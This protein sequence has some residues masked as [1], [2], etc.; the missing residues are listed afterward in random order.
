MINPNVF[1][2]AAGQQL[3]FVPV[4]QLAHNFVQ[5]LP[6]LIGLQMS[7]NMAPY[8]QQLVSAAIQN[9]QDKA[10]SNP[11]R[12]FFFNVMAA[13]GFD[14]QMFRAFVQELS[15][16]TELMCIASNRQPQQSIPECVDAFVTF[17]VGFMSLQNPNV[18]QRMPQQSLMAMQQAVQEFQASLQNVQQRMRQAQSQPM[19][20]GMQGGGMGMGGSM[21]AQSAGFSPTGGSIFST[22]A[23]PMSVAGVGGMNIA[24]ATAGSNINTNTPAAT[25]A[26]VVTPFETSGSSNVNLQPMVAGTDGAVFLSSQF[27]GAAAPAPAAKAEV[28]GPATVTAVGD[29]ES[30]KWKP[31]SKFLVMPTFDPNKEELKFHV[32]SDGSIQ[33]LIAAKTMDMNKHLE[34]IKIT[35]G[36][37]VITQQQALARGEESVQKAVGPE[38]LRVEL[39]PE[40]ASFDFSHKE[41]WT[42]NEAY[43]LSIRDKWP[44]KTTMTLKYSM[45]GDTLIASPAIIALIHQLQ[46]TPT[47]T[48]AVNLLKKTFKEAVEA[49]LNLDIRA[50]NRIVRRLWLRTNRFIAV[51]MSLNFG[52]IDKAASFVDDYPQLAGFL[53]TKLGD[54]SADLFEQAHGT[55]MTEALTLA[56]GELKNTIDNG[57]FSDVKL[58]PQQQLEFIHLYDVVAYGV[59]DL[60]TIQLRS[61]IPKEGFSVMISE[62]STP[63]MAELAKRLFDR[64]S[65]QEKGGSAFE[66]DRHLLRT[67]D[68]V[69]LEFAKAAFSSTEFVVALHQGE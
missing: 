32:Y 68:G 62:S 35:P 6:N 23:A 47:P 24:P 7:P 34:P 50:I 9:I 22:T 26:P 28:I 16:Y 61:E 54:R 14:N 46:R 49:Q 4:D 20:Y 18:Q 36:W 13:N 40:D 42:T 52:K 27:Q 48:E 11:A 31:S 33:P 8:G 67:N 45:L 56:E 29:L 10:T 66:C 21:G 64:K 12:T 53:R 15:Q 69:V 17:R 63:L 38:D 19:N 43:M 3:L 2:Q 51:D 59:V 41:N 25:N 65:A 1:S 57:V 44:N 37:S 55:I 58:Q 60:S 30:V 39:Y 5:Q